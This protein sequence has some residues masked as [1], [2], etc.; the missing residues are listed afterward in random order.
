[1]AKIVDNVEFEP[2]PIT[3]LPLTETQKSCEYCHNFKNLTVGNQ[4]D[5][6]EVADGWIAKTHN[7]YG[8][9]RV[10]VDVYVGNFNKLVFDWCGYVDFEVI[11][12]C[13][14]CGRKLE[15]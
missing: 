15:D 1:M 9:Y 2:G 8:D 7:Y 11:N 10:G 6:V 5:Q 14:M 4:F 3:G 12:Y 13:P